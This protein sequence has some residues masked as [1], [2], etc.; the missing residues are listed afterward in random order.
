MRIREI[1]EPQQFQDLCQQVLAAEHDDFQ[2]LDDSRGDEG[3]DGYIPSQRRLF[4]IYCPEKHPTPPEYYKTKINKDLRKAVR[5]RD[6]LGYEIDDW[7]FVTPSPLTE[8]LHRYISD[9]AKA[10]GFNRGVNWSEKHILPRLLKHD[11]L[12]QLFPDLFLP[13]IQ[14]ELQTG[15][16]ETTLLQREAIS[17]HHKMQAGIDT[18]ITRLSVTE[19]FQQKF[20]SRV[21]EEY[22][23][24]FKA[25]KELF[26]R[27]LYLRAREAYQQ[28]LQD[29]KQDDAAPD[30]SLFSKACTNTALCDWHLDDLQSAAQW[31]EEAYSYQP[32][33]RKM[34]ANLATAQM[35]RRDPETAL[36]TIER[37]LA[38]GPEDEDSIT[39]KANVLSS[40]GRIAEAVDFLEKA[41]RTKLQLF[42]KGLR[43]QGEGSFLEAAGVFRE[44]LKD[45]PQNESYLEYAGTALLLGYQRILLRDRVMPWKMPAEMRK[46]LEEAEGLLTQ[47]VELLKTREAPK[48]LMGLYVNRSAARVVLGR[49]K[50]AVSDC[51][52][53]IKIDPDQPDAY[54]NKSKAAATAE[55]FDAAIES[56]E[57]YARLTGGIGERA[58]DLAYYHYMARRMDKA[59]EFILSAGIGDVVTKEG[60]VSGYLGLAVNVFDFNQDFELADE[61]IGRIEEKFPDHPDTLVI[62]ARHLVQT[63]G[64]GAEELLRRA[65]SV[66][67]PR[68]IDSITTELANY[69]LKVGN[70]R[71][72][73]P[74]YEQIIS[75]Q[76]VTPF[77]QSFLVCLYYEGRFAEAVRFAEKL[78]GD[79]DID[80]MITPIEAAAHIALWHFPEASELLLALYQREPSRIDYLVEYGVCLFRM[81]KKEKALRAFDQARNRITR[82]KELLAL[83]QGY[84]SLGQYQAAVELSYRA[85]RQ[86]PHLSRVHKAYV[87]CY[88]GAEQAGEAP[89]E[90]KYVNAYQD[91]LN[92]YQERF[93]EDKSFI[94]LE[95]G[96][97]ESEFFKFL[98]EGAARFAQILDWY[99]GGALPL[100]TIAVRRRHS[101]FTIWSSL[102]SSKEFGVR[103]AIG[104][105]EE[106]AAE[107]QTASQSQQ[108]VVD[109]LALF[110]LHRAGQL[111]LL[112]KL[113]GR[114]LV[115]QA[116][117][118]ELLSLLVEERRYTREGRVTIARVGD[119]YV[120]FETPAGEI[121]RGITFLEEIK[122]FVRDKCEIKGLREE[123]RSTDEPVV[124]FFGVS[125][126][127]SAVLASQEGVP[128]LSDDGLLRRFAKLNYSL[129]GFPTHSLFG[130]AR[131]REALS[132]RR[133]AGLMIEL[134]RWNYH[135]IPVSSDF[136][137]YCGVHSGWRS[138]GSFELALEEL[139]RAETSIESLSLVITEFLTRIWLIPF[140]EMMKS[141][142]LWRVLRVITKN[143]R[144][145]EAIEGLLNSL[146]AQLLNKDPN[147]IYDRISDQIS[148]WLEK[149]HSRLQQEELAQISHPEDQPASEQHQLADAARS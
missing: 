49:G 79:V 117:F 83:A 131:D 76:E 34:I 133:Y 57:S 36:N 32:D 90:E 4:A 63:G 94:S 33:E 75:D 55:D 71:E 52:E 146:H 86:S 70:Y 130:M 44:L 87:S 134:L 23:K 50:E 48:R 25:G 17:L 139:G 111:S 15:F 128:L 129:E 1:R 18:V 108:V 5:L 27:G 95:V 140:P 24:R 143:H 124:R 103:T 65:L 2:V 142:I 29:L 100:Y 19:D 68:E 6:E 85:L 149:N 69:L 122:N 114:P 126:A 137:I 141:I 121:Q 112:E 105:R 22:D 113:F 144:P 38:M 110:T 101:L 59:K 9:E 109:L 135:Y 136:L 138:G 115:H 35:F 67:E 107:G 127:H 46:D 11:Y 14:K 92:K 3:N 53:A 20:T 47:A 7:F 51:D 132:V 102:S 31:F 72:A 123:L 10:A 88:M 119:E 41:G 58:K 42:F 98:D 73:L 61:L 116:V 81:D 84:Y 60:L 64:Q 120:R 145:F 56:L 74:L 96:D 89:A 91:T 99:K 147:G 82:T 118:E 26:D 37:A 8:E 106:Q 21:A 97:D 125:A 54:L 78:R 80:L 40:A 93:P 77:H 28:I 30:R 43:L 12:K 62:R 148:E 66:A 13:D 39:I 16:S 104:D 45:E